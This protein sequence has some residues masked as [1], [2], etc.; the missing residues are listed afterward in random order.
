VPQLVSFSSFVVSGLLCISASPHDTDP[1]DSINSCI[2]E[3]K[4]DCG[5]LLFSGLGCTS[6]S[7]SVMLLIMLCSC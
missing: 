7:N 4:V 2:F 3:I 6:V 1:T 5:S